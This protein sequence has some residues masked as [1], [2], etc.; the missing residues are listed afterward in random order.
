M[1]ARTRGIKIGR[2]EECNMT[3]SWMSNASLE[4]ARSPY[5]DAVMLSLKLGMPSFDIG[6]NRSS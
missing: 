1:R 2:I 3:V 6:P 5:L 4:A